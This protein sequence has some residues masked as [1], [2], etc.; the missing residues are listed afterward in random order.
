MNCTALD[1]CFFVERNMP[2]FPL[3]RN[4]DCRKLKISYLKVK[5]SASADCPIEKFTKYIF[6]DDIKSKGKKTIFESLGFSIKDSQMLKFEIE[7]QCLSNY[8]LG[9]YVLKNSDI[10][11]QRLAIPV[12]L[13]GKTFY[14]GWMLEPGGK[15]RNTTPFGGFVK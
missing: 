4:C 10:T 2:L 3:H 5:L 7:K 8:L 14:V 11:G 15:L 13:S 12:T 6:T 1:G 9:N